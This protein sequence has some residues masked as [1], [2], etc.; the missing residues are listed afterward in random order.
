METYNKN[1]IKC[2]NYTLLHNTVNA[3]VSVCASAQHELDSS[4]SL[5]LSFDSMHS[6]GPAATPRV[7]L[8]ASE[9]GP[10]KNA[11]R[12]CMVWNSW[13]RSSSNPRWRVSD[14]SVLWKQFLTFGNIFTGGVRCAKFGN[15]DERP[16]R[17][18]FSLR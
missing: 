14:G 15:T 11:T 2:N 13:K 6:A 1:N 7:V 12:G 9:K 5:F 17:N 3:N 10:V 8:T 16:S 18:S 4:V